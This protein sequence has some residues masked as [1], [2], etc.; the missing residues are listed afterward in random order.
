MSVLAAFVLP[1]PPIALSAI[2]KGEEAKIQST[3]EGFR[4]VARE[5]AVLQPET[6]VISSPH[7]PLYGD[8]F[9]VSDN[10]RE[11]GDFGRFRAKEVKVDV[12]TDLDFV[13]ALKRSNRNFLV[14]SS[15]VPELDHGVMVPLHFIKQAYPDF[16]LVR[17]GLSMLPFDTHVAI[18]KTIRDVAESLG[19]RIVFIA[20]G[21]L[22]HRLAHDGP[23]GYAKEG[24]R[25]DKIIQ[26]VLENGDFEK[27]RSISAGMCEQAGECGY[28]S[29]VILSGVVDGMGFSA[30]LHSYEGTFGVG[31]ATASFLP[32][33][34]KAQDPYLRLARLSVEN[35]V[36]NHRET[37]L[38][39]DTPDELLKKR[40][41]VFVSLHRRGQLRGCIGTISPTQFCVGKEVLRNAVSACSEDPRFY[42]VRPEEL[43]ELV[44]N[45]DVLLPPETIQYASQLDV[46]KYGVIVS[47]GHR[48]G[49]LLPDLDGVDTIAKQ[50]EIA[51][52][53]GGIEAD[54]DYVLQRFEVVRHHE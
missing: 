4:Q 50:I 30:K 18:G 42:P 34:M 53:K 51:L 2:G 49:L 8:A 35:Y 20:S 38:P 5:I 28:R 47:K 29:L 17:I 23:Y 33:S 36:R 3:I 45:V 43:S 1:H 27:L 44:Y 41:G 25:F 26:S 46:K 12:K 32:K 14:G 10:L 13:Q 52:S 7:S 31:Y 6:I 48:K 21:D 15:E 39:L 37:E 11:L 22:S 19:R 54:E 40:A 24:P 16:K 9:F